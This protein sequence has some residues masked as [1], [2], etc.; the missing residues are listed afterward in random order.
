MRFKLGLFVAALLL[1]ACAQQ[2]EPAPAA[3]TGSP[4]YQQGQPANPNAAITPS[5]RGRN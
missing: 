4:N 1:S 5:T 2:P 3:R